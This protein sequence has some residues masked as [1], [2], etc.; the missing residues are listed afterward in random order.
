[1]QKENAERSE[2]LFAAG[3]GRREVARQPPRSRADLVS[4]AKLK[5]N[6]TNRETE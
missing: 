6:D 5:I 1:M 2:T 3:S 4:H